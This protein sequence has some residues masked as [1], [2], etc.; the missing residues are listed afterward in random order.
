M[1][2]GG[3]RILRHVRG[4]YISVLS[5]LLH[6]LEPGESVLICLVLQSLVLQNERLA[7]HV[8]T[9]CDRLLVLHLRCVLTVGQLNLDQDFL[10]ELVEQRWDAMHAILA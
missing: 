2:D 7:K 4:H 1:E 8:L 3:K 6:G 10:Q 5:Q 9:A